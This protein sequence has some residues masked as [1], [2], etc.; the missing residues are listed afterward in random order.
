MANL[1]T[2]SAGVVDTGGKLQPAGGKLAVGVC[3]ANAIFSCK[4]YRSLFGDDVYEGWEPVRFSHM[5]HLE[6]SIFNSVPFSL[7]FLYIDMTEV[8]SFSI[9]QRPYW[10][11]LGGPH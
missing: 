8:R 9:Y 6:F 1:A 2:S 7:R 3:A 5:S 4:V 11:P 10:P